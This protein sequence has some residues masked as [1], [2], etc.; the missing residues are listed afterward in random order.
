LGMALQPKLG[1]F[2]GRES[3]IVYDFDDVLSL[4]APRPCLIVSP[5]RDRD[6]DFTDVQA[7]MDKSINAWEA[8]GARKALTHKAPDDVNRFQMDQHKIFL[9]WV[10]KIET[11]TRN[12]EVTAR[13]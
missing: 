2:Q 1:L 9:E 13:Q 7:C 5:Q 12:E 4:V 10:E 3:E 11:P 8:K 6:A